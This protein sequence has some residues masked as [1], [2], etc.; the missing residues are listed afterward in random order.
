MT[1]LCIQL[2]DTGT[3]MSAR[4]ATRVMM[5]WSTF[6]PWIFIPNASWRHGS[7]SR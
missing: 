2:K 5:Q 3:C 6:T 4:D 7:W 1:S